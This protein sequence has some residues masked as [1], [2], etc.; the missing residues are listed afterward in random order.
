MDRNRMSWHKKTHKAQVNCN[1][2]NV[3]KDF[4]EYIIWKKEMLGIA[5]HKAVVNADETNVHFSPSFERTITD[6]GSRTVAILQPN[7]AK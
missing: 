3:I 2:T 6:G 4:V 7:S 5:D 1:D